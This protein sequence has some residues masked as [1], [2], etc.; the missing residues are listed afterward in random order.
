MDHFTEV[1]RSCL[2]RISP[3]LSKRVHCFPEVGADMSD[4]V[5]APR[6][7]FDELQ[8]RQSPELLRDIRLTHSSELNKLPCGEFIFGEA[9]Y[10]C[11]DAERVAA[12]TNQAGVLVNFH[13]PDAG[14]LMRNANEALTPLQYCEEMREGDRT[15]VRPMRGADLPTEGRTIAWSSGKEYDLLAGG[16]ELLDL[17]VLSARSSAAAKRAKSGQKLDD[18]DQ[19]SLTELA[20]LLESAAET[21]EFFGTNGQIGALPTGA[22]AAQLDVAIDTVAIEMEDVSNTADIVKDL[23]GLADDA[24]VF[25]SNQTPS[26]PDRAIVFFRDLSASI[27]RETGRIGERTSPL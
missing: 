12:A 26:N 25:A 22:L 1:R 3:F 5:P 19:E 18:P 4:V 6:E 11:P 16:A 17:G 2:P 7:C 23:R 8:I 10:S 21:V 9:C 13:R 15:Y 24:R 27:L 20:S 14:Y